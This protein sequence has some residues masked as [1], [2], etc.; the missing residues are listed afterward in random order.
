MVSPVT[1]VV[2]FAA[3]GEARAFWADLD[4]DQLLQAQPK[5]RR[6]LGALQID[7][8]TA[9]I[10]LDVTAT[11]F[12][13]LKSFTTH[14]CTQV[15]DKV[16]R[17]R[18][19]CRIATLALSEFAYHRQANESF[20]KELSK[21]LKIEDS[22]T[23]QQCFHHILSNGFEALGV[24]RARGQSI[25]RR[26]FVAT[27]YLQNGIPV[28]HQTRFATLLSELRDDYGWWEIAHSSPF[29]ISEL[30][31]HDC[32][33]R[34]VAWG[35]I[36]R[37]LSLSCPNDGE[38]AQPISGELTQSLAMIATELNR[39]GLDARMLID[40][41]QRNALLAG[42]DI[43]NAFFLRNWASIAQLLRFNPTPSTDERI[44]S[45]Q[46]RPLTL[47]LEPEDW[48]EIQLVLPPQRIYKLEWK[49]RSNS[50][51]C[52]PGADE[53]EFDIDTAK[54]IL[55]LDR[56]ITTSVF[57]IGD[58]WRWQ[59]RMGAG[60]GEVAFEW[61]CR[62]V[63]STSPMLIF[64][65]V[66][67]ER[68]EASADLGSVRELVIFTP[69]DYDL[70]DGS[71]VEVL[72]RVRWC[73][74]KGW[75]GFHLEKRSEDVKL[76]FSSGD[77]VLCLDWNSQTSQVPELRG[78]RIHD[79]KLIFSSAPQ[80][81]IPPLEHAL[82]VHVRVDDLDRRASLTAEDDLISLDANSSWQCIDLSEC[83]QDSCR[84]AVVVWLEQEHPF[85]P[86]RWEQVARVSLKEMV[87]D[88]FT[89]P[90]PS[91]L[92]L[93]SDR[94]QEWPFNPELVPLVLLEDAEFWLP[95]WRL[96]GL[97]P[98]ETIT[99][100]LR[101]GEASMNVVLSAT[102]GGEIEVEMATFRFS[103]ADSEHYEF[104]LQR[105]GDLDP[106]LICV[107]GQS[108]LE[109]ITWDSSTG[110]LAGLSS[111]NAYHLVVWN[112]LTSNR[113]PELIELVANSELMNIDF[114]N[115]I[116]E[117]AGLYYLELRNER[118][119]L[120]TIGWWSGIRS[121]HEIFP[122]GIDLE[123]LS[124]LLDN[125]PLE[126]F[127]GNFSSQPHAL[128]DQMLA[129]GIDALLNPQKLPAWLDLKLLRNK[130][131]IWLQPDD[132][133][134]DTPS[135]PIADIPKE[136]S[137]KITLQIE[138][139]PF[140][141]WSNRV[142]IEATNKFIQSF[143]IVRESIGIPP[144]EVRIES[145]SADI[146][147]I[148]RSSFFREDLKEILQKVGEQQQI[149]IRQGEQGVRQKLLV[150]Q[151][152]F[153]PHQDHSGSRR[154]QSETFQ[155]FMIDCRKNMNISPDAIRFS[156]DQATSLPVITVSNKEQREKLNEMLA[157]AESELSVGI[158]ITRIRE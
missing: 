96:K 150:F 56:E 157:E 138:P 14:S 89:Q 1:Q 84:V 20:W 13:R 103:L 109:M 44:R 153:S 147:V 46:R 2:D 6:Y 143:K 29:A 34:H 59:L 108:S 9:E 61:N 50:F 75:W 130:L 16:D 133:V 93:H 106:Q 45:I 49:N 72:E 137:I 15:F 64:D 35:T 62:G 121:K 74:I 30:L 40:E 100:H 76:S 95:L 127:M 31:H 37:F 26:L 81:W 54:G 79:R 82:D 136:K 48:G 71:D 107:L 154:V 104:S 98:F 155:E 111:G 85:L 145:L 24:V 87:I 10:L 135:I 86:R 5:D 63:D 124:N 101:S 42:F 43:P 25:E 58:L 83:I 115:Y 151:V 141:R 112:L 152:K 12:V 156:I 146:W 68:L 18:Y 53:A 22:K 38:D 102:A 11:N 28:Q 125:E 129:R 144:D 114:H 70:V 131:E 128:S 4:V 88:P 77:S 23:T 110:I 66:S 57:A 67:G 78:E 126:E 148:L 73:S 119:H 140:F 33:H 21:R 94:N 92:R 47:R 41:T 3:L 116:S 117:P 158:S 19:W 51:C 17:Q 120:L 55:N 27:L 7:Q 69:R 39:R 80:V 52:I 90:C 123:L 139:I 118:Q 36:L 97:W 91:L 142:R 65:S 8:E 99:I 149:S 113:S 132:S 134:D 105:Q 122:G 32:S 60:D